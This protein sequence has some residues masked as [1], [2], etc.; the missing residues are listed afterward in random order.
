MLVNVSRK[1]QIQTS[2]GYRERNY[3]DQC[4]FLVGLE[5]EQV[6]PSPL[7][8]I[9][10][11]FCVSRLHLVSRLSLFLCLFLRSLIASIR[12]KYKGL[13]PDELNV[14]DGGQTAVAA[15]P[16]SDDPPESIIRKWSHG[17]FLM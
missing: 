7:Y 10:S 11:F 16:L 12:L 2:N 9:F 14:H 3:F 1:G 8:P 17:T 15:E 6:S 4:S 5:R 13:L